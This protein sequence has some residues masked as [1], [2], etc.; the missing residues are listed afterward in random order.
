MNLLKSYRSALAVF[1][2]AVSVSA[3]DLNVTGMDNDVDAAM[4]LK[5]WLADIGYTSKLSESRDV[6][7]LQGDAN[8]LIAP[9]V[10]DG[11]VD[12]LVIYKTFKG[13]A[14]NHGSAELQ[15]IVREI[16]ER[17]NVCCVYVDKGGDLQL[18]YTLLFDDKLSPKLF[19]QTM[20]HVKTCTTTIITE[21]R[22][23]FRPFYD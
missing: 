23:R 3:A 18:R 10:D 14:S 15:S 22:D 2:M 6:V 13:K 9:K 17:F 16:N 20:E 4:S 5:A 8:Y 19:R 7:F 12:R 21:Y 1:M 11:D